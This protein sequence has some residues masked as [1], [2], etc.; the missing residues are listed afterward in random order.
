MS[1]DKLSEALHRRVEAVLVAVGARP[2]GSLWVLGNRLQSQRVDPG[3]TADHAEQTCWF[4]PDPRG[5]A[6]AEGRQVG[7][8]DGQ[9][10]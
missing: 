1:L 6:D 2:D 10:P 7:P 8:A 5:P 4:G 9:G 3:G